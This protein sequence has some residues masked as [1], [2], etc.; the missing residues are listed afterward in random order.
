V[1]GIYGEMRLSRRE[2]ELLDKL[3]ET[4]FVLSRC[5]REAHGTTS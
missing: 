1:I 5:I 2:Q 4:R 3:E